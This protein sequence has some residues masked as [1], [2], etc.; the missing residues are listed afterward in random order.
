MLSWNS[1]S[2][3]A[4]S[5]KK[6]AVTALAALH[7]VGERDADRE[8]QPAADDRVAAIEPGRAV[9]DVHRSAA[10]AAASFLL[11]EHLGHQ[12]V[13]ADAA[14]DRL[15][16]LAIGRDDGVLGR[17]RLHDAD[18]NRLL[19]IIEVQKAE[20]LLRLVQLDAFRL[21]MPDADHLAQ[22]MMQMGVVETDL[23]A[24][25]RSSLV[26]FEGG[27]IAF[28][29]AEFARLQQPA[30]DLA[31][32]GFRQV[33]AE[34]DLLRRHRRAEPPP[35]RAPAGRGAALPRAQSPASARQTP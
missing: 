35:A 19:A 18:R 2:S 31:A 29:K 9:E 30:H 4:P 5:P 27:Q 7:L 8:R 22:Q 1:P 14:R 17:K 23:G 15:A 12:P 26:A 20:D 24:D 32:A 25:R 10:P 11:A 6:Q 21:E 34:V 28:G 16:V 3:T 13:H 33:G